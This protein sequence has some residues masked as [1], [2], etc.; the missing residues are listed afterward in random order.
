MRQRPALFRRLMQVAVGQILPALDQES[1]GLLTVIS[2]G[3]VGLLIRFY[4]GRLR[5]FDVS[6]KIVGE[7]VG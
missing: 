4:W 3:V 5:H 2:H 1:P 7:I 6:G